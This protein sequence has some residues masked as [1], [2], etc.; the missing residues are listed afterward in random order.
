[1]RMVISKISNS[2]S[3][4]SLFVRDEAILVCLSMI[5][6]GTSY[7]VFVVPNF[8]IGVHPES[9]NASSGGR[10]SDL[11][12]RGADRSIHII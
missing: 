12:N 5:T 1:M 2:T 7:Y 9:I 10:K 3:L 11:A 8:E 4:S 6:Y